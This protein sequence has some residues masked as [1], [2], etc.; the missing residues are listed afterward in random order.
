MS[1]KVNIAKM[2]GCFPERR[3]QWIHAG[4]SEG[5]QLRVSSQG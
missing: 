3:Y 2:A 1:E 5:K 4:T